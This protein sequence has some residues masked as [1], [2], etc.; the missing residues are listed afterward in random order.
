MLKEE[1]NFGIKKFET[2]NDEIEYLI[3]HEQRN[4]FITNL[5]LEILKILVNIKYWQRLC[6]AS[7]HKKN[8]LSIFSD[9]IFDMRRLK[10]PIHHQ[11]IYNGSMIG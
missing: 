2:Y 9:F 10:V 3:S 8:I 4:K 5:T 11:Y 1:E 7:S 6:I